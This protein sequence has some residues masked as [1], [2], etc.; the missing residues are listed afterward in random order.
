MKA[1]VLQAPYQLEMCD[2]AEPEVPEGYA[3]VRLSAVSICGSD[4][5]AYRGNSLLL[6]YPRIIG[7]E[8]CGIVEEIKDGKSSVRPG[9]KVSILP[10]I[11]CGKCHA[12][13][14]GRENCCTSLKV[15]GVHVE[16]GLAE[17]V[18]VPASL[19]LKLPD[20]MDSKI[21]A[22]IEPLS[23]S[24]HCVRRGNVGK[25]D[26]VLVLGAGPIGL[27]AAEFSRIAG[28]DVRIADVNPVRRAFASDVFGYIA[29]DP[30]ADDF[31][32]TLRAWTHEEY[33]SI[34]IDSTGNKKSN[35]VAINYLGAAGNL[36][37]VGLQSDILAI[38]DPAFHV[39]EATVFAS[40]VAQMRDFEYVLEC[41]ETGKIHPEKMIT[42]TAG[43][44]RAKEAFEEWF[45]SGGAVF[46]GVIE[47]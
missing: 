37:F 3:K 36:V 14:K 23:V 1:L 28:A 10:Y 47:L 35:D 42:N 24:A 26:R 41:I 13:R 18:S 43:F 34:V 44:D 12:C 30:S 5:H 29:L 33:P 16:G 38:S 27:G 45:A 22:L 6:T 7:H 8:L 19:L 2:V 40:R 11:S 15:L 46:K 25:D 32:Q 9:D 21:A 39:R 31:D 20:D 17:H 4:Y